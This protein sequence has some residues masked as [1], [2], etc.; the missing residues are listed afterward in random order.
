LQCN[1]FDE[2]TNFTNQLLQMLSS[3]C[4]DIA[5]AT[6]GGSK[7][8]LGTYGIVAEII[9]DQNF[10]CKS[11]GLVAFED[12][13]SFM[14]ELVAVHRA[15]SALHTAT[16]TVG[17]QGQ[18]CWLIDC[19]GVLDLL[20]DNGS[21]DRF[22][23]VESISKKREELIAMGVVINTHWVPSHG[24]QKADYIPPSCLGDVR[25]RA[26]NEAADQQATDA[27]LLVSQTIA[28]ETMISWLQSRDRAKEW[29]YCALKYASQVGRMYL[30]HLLGENCRP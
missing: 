10:Q 1:P 21:A 14:A 2:D 11:G 27:R 20:L 4:G 29:Q 5:I 22:L 30:R 17:W 19:K 18:V 16:R 8:E 9:D 24:K 7:D 12:N 26:L 13:Q 6:D 23:C 15:V 25:A 3:G 28:H